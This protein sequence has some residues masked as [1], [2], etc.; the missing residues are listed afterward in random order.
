[1]SFFKKSACLAGKHEQPFFPTVGTPDA[2]K[3]AHRIAAVQVLLDHFLDHRTE[4]AVLL[5]KPILIFSQ[6]L[7]KVIKN[8]R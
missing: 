6:K 7:L 1:M 2:V 3:S 4:K 8:T 5:F